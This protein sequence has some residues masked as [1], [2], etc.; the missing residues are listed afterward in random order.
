MALRRLLPLAQLL[1]GALW[2]GSLHACGE[3]EARRPNVVLVSIDTLRA[4]HLSC[5]GYRRATSPGLDRLA[6]GG[7]LFERT[8]APTSW[9][10]PSHVSMLTGLEISLHGIAA[11]LQ[12]GAAKGRET[13]RPPSLFGRFLPELLSEA[14]YRTGGFYSWKY[15][16]PTFGFGPGFEVYERL[17]HTLYSHPVASKRLEEARAAGDPAALQDLARDF[18]ELCDPGHKSTPEVLERARAWIAETRADTPERPFFCF[19]HLFDVHD[20]YVPP[21]PFDTRFDPDYA[22]PIDGRD[23]SSNDLVRPGMDPRDLEHLVALYDGEIAYV[24][25]ELGAFL[26]GLAEQ[27]LAED[28]LILVT[29][30]HGEEFYEHRQKLHGH[31]LYLE[32]VRVPW[33][34]SWPGE[35]PAGLRIPQTAGLVDLA[36]TVLGLLGLPAPEGLSGR[37]LAPVVRGR[38][39]HGQPTYLTELYLFDAGPDVRRQFGLHRGR[40]H[41]LLFADGDEPFRL[42]R[43]DAASNP[44][45]RHGTRRARGSRDA[46]QATA[47]LEQRLDHLRALRRLAPERPAG[48]TGGLTESDLAELQ[49]LGYFPGGEAP[50]AVPQPEA[51]DLLPADAAYWSPA[52]R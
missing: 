2:A 24:D 40:A 39:E 17:G 9:T 21:P 7:V 51:S 37:D 27:S 6:A 28:T 10:L 44:L 32:S 12:W 19:V 15:L 13:A 38:A 26:D 23:V 4:D 1:A 22:G 45:G 47:E 35:L 30:D 18:P 31:Q 11:D 20:P 25:A 34:L 46:R 48:A 14:G 43:F 41:D 42:E 50:P 5:Y 49:A 29:S 33:I 36:P 52:P 8:V 3:P 16:E